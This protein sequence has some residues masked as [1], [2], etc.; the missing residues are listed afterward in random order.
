MD[1]LSEIRNLFFTNEEVVLL[2]NA[3]FSF[4]KINP[5]IDS[6]TEFRRIF[7]DVLLTSSECFSGKESIF[8]FFFLQPKTVE[9]SIDI[10]E[11]IAIQQAIV[12]FYYNG[13]LDR[14]HY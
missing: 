5:A 10:N 8:T 4:I 13:N 3:C 2:S 1:F 11:S 12:C 9:G 14:I 6:S 7:F